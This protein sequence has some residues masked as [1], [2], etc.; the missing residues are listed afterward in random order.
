MLVY[1]IGSLR[2]PLVPQ[3]AAQLRAAGY[4]VFD[5][6]FAAGEHADDA[7][8]DYERG[9]GH[10]LP[11]ALKGEAAWHI[12]EFDKKW[13]DKADVAILMLPAGKS[14]HLELGYVCGCGKPTFVLLDKDPDRYDVMYRFMSGVS[15]TV[16]D[17]LKHMR[18]EEMRAGAARRMA[19]PGG[20]S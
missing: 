13:L 5:D 2:N 10:T 16:E 1:L 18:G 12:F 17:L 20:N 3:V 15:A 8:R 7:W 11:E 14:G 19:E 9:R 6:W 4:S